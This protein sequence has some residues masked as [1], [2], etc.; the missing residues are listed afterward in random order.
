MWQNRVRK[1]LACTLPEAAATASERRQTYQTRVSS[2]GSPHA[3]ALS[4]D[5]CSAA[6]HH[7]G[8]PHATALSADHCSAAGHHGGS[9]HATALSADHCSA[10]GHHGGSPHATALSA[11]HCSAA[12]HHG[13]AVAGFGHTGIPL[14]CYLG[15]PYDKGD[16]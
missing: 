7:G 8:S 6:G 11:D 13:G 9:P 12:G 1:L 2:G 4:A 10:V 5:H 15:F 14:L 16:S 3:T